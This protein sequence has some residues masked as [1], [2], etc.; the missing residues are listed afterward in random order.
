MPPLDFV[1]DL[2][3]IVISYYFLTISQM[4]PLTCCVWGLQ[5]VVDYEFLM[6]L[7]GYRRCHYE[8]FVSKDQNS[9]F[10]TQWQE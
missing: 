1:C 5:F 4:P 9:V 10:H 3:S 7:V 6:I 2:T 8:G